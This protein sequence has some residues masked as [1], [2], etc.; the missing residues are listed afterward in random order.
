MK[1]QTIW[2]LRESV[3]PTE[4][5][6]IENSKAQTNRI[7]ESGRREVQRGENE[8][9]DKQTDS[10]EE[11]L[12]EVEKVQNTTSNAMICLGPVDQ[13]ILKSV[14]VKCKA[15]LKP[16]IGKWKRPARSKNQDLG[17]AREVPVEYLQASGKKRTLV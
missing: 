17:L 16:G 10:G 6:N 7:E 12:M 13:N 14:K 1:E 8:G 5:T 15:I 3:I 2:E 9:K 11:D 4:L